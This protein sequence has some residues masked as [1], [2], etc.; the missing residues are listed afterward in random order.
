MNEVALQAETRG[1]TG[2]GVARKLRAAGRIPATL[3]GRDREPLSLT[4]NARE[5]YK[6]LHGHA[7]V[8]V[9]LDV[10]GE[11]HLA[12]PRAVQ[13]HPIRNEILH[14]D[15][16]EVSRTQRVTV[17]VAIHF[18]GEAP[19]VK[20]GGVVEHIHNSLSIECKAVEVPEY[21]VAD[22]SGLGVDGVLHVSDLKIPADVVVHL[23]AS[24]LIA[25]CAIPKLVTEAEL[26]SAEPIVEG[27]ESAGT[28][29]A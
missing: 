11:K 4:L 14:V 25:T 24:E 5:A 28:E 1:D 19:G 16:M 17:D 22:I 26:E 2:K 7:N 10:A 21:L 15:F 3:Y 23:D 29:G 27:K 20:E 18:E 6:V 8:L 12:L 13:P 9:G